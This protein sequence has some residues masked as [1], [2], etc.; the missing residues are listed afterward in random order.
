MQCAETRTNVDANKS[1]KE[2]EKV[3]SLTDQRVRG[4]LLK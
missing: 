3:G 2:T 1:L 4:G